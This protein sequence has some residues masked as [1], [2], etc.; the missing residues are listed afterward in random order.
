M[1]E[2]RDG[3]KK[4]GRNGGREGRRDG[5]KPG[6]REAGMEGWKDGRMEGRIEEE[7]ERGRKKSDSRAIS[8]ILLDDTINALSLTVESRFP[9]SFS[10]LLRIGVKD[11]LLNIHEI[12]PCFLA[13]FSS[14]SGGLAN[15]TPAFLS[16][17]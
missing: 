5:G 14:L 13:C 1:E 4:E 17:S 16:S 8:G 7:S 3:G 10:F 6:W 2:G 9:L 15:V 12:S 11:L